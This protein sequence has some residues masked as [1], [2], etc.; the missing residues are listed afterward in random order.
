MGRVGAGLQITTPRSN[1]SI[2]GSLDKAHAYYSEFLTNLGSHFPM[3]SLTQVD[4]DPFVL[5]H[6]GAFVQFPAGHILLY[7]TKFSHSLA[8]CLPAPKV[9]PSKSAY[10]TEEKIE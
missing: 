7:K 8:P 5:G 2:T 6:S 10:D 4:E 3:L 9:A 1:S